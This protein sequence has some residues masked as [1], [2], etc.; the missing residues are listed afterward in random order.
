MT[1]PGSPSELGLLTLDLAVSLLS[2]VLLHEDQR[3]RALLARISLSLYAAVAP[4]RPAMRRWLETELTAGFRTRPA[5]E[6]VVGYSELLRV[7]DAVAR[8]YTGKSS[9]PSFR[10]V[11]AMA[12]A[13]AEAAHVPNGKYNDTDSVLVAYHKELC[14]LLRHLSALSGAAADDVVRSI[15]ASWPTS[16]A[17]KEALLVGSMEAAYFGRSPL[18]ASV[19][20]R[21]G[22][23]SSSLNF[24]G[25]ERALTF[26]DSEAMMA[27]VRAAPEA[28]VGD[29]F[30]GLYR[31]GELHW[32][33]TVNVMTAVVLESVEKEAPGALSRAAAA[34]L[35]MIGEARGDLSKWTRYLETL[36]AFRRKSE[37]E[38]RPREVSAGA[39]EASIAARAAPLRHSDFV[40]GRDLGV[41]SF[42]TVRFAKL[43]E[44]GVPQKDWHEVAVKS[45]DLAH[46][47]QQ[48]YL[49]NVEREISLLSEL[50]HPC[51]ARLHASFRDAKSIHLVCEYASGGD[52]FTQLQQLGS[53]TAEAARFALAEVVL[54]LGYLDERGIAFND[55]KPENIILDA[56]RH[57]KLTDFGSACRYADLPAM[58]GRDGTAAY[59]PP[60]AARRASGMPG[61]P[62]EGNTGDLWA[63]GILAYQLLAGRTPFWAAESDE[64]ALRRITVGF[65]P[66]AAFPAGFPE[67]AKDLVTRLL[68]PAPRDRIDLGAVRRHPFFEGIDWVS[69]PDQTPPRSAAGIAGPSGGA[70]W[71]QRSYSMLH[72]PVA[73]QYDYSS[74]VLDLLPAVEPEAP[75]A[76]AWPGQRAPPSAP[77][78]S[79]YAGAGEKH[80][81]QQQQQS[82]SPAQ[83]A[84]QQQPFVSPALVQSAVG[85]T[86]QQAMIL[87]GVWPGAPGAPPSRK[88]PTGVSGGQQQPKRSLL[89]GAGSER[90]PKPK[91]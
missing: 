57:C 13:V 15:L 29:L 53:L 61:P 26:M 90:P 3:C 81:Q 89:S 12:R 55:L 74:T 48:G 60:E 54:A 4:F 67:Q 38:R 72:A 73:A 76:A 85:L 77:T 82:Q 58:S 88:L 59:L 11:V 71:A 87:T 86:P 5:G 80:N 6:L 62:V 34:H 37:G 47:E 39:V 52:L 75:G 68:A 2:Q 40:F 20:Q 78:E 84:Q 33:P 24:R 91:G 64:D 22:M 46:L 16:N 51:I 25:A 1:L 27:T 18:P 79:R 44:V 23:C 49:A 83:A 19:I 69:L 10:S 17:S 14:V 65:D 21:C 35:E 66:S 36:T 42:S 70:K 32:N 9:H 45:L 31:G 28:T 30:I 41:G 63:L 50:R 8:G 7:V 43:R 56:R